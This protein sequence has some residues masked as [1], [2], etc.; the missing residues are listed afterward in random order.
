MP[1]SLAGPEGAAMPIKQ[2][3]AQRRDRLTPASMP[4]VNLRYQPRSDSDRGAYSRG[5][6]RGGSVREVSVGVKREMEEDV[7]LV[8]AQKRPRVIIDLTEVD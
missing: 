5:S 6:V 8:A 1:Q 7:E 2:E 3:P 4:A